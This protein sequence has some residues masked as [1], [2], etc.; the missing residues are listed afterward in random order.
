MMPEIEEIQSLLQDQDK[1][2][3]IVH[4]LLKESLKRLQRF[5]LKSLN[6]EISYKKFSSVF[7]PLKTIYFS[8]VIDYQKL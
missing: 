8:L 6:F 2:F 1:R 4:Y 7:T 5:S 3:T